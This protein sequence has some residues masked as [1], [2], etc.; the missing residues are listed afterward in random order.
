[1][2]S[3]RG[4]IISLNKDT[5]RHVIEI[6]VPLV[7]IGMMVGL[8]GSIGLWVFSCFQKDADTKRRLK[9]WSW[10]VGGGL[11]VSYFA[12]MAGWSLFAR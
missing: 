2:K 12:L 11:L 8:P 3:V 4:N 1:M 7:T 6:F 10:I 9:R 5:M